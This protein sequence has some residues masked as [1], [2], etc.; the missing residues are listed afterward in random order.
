MTLSQKKLYNQ[1]NKPVYVNC[2]SLAKEIINDAKEKS[3]VA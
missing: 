3:K 1:R 2:I